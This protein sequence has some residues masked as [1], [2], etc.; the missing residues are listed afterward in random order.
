MRLFV[1][2]TVIVAAV[3]AG[4]QDG[5]RCRG[6]L[7][8][9]HRQ[10]VEGFVA[11]HSLAEA[12]ATLTSIPARPRLRPSEVWR[13]LQQNVLRHFRVVRLETDEVVQVLGDLAL[14][15]IA[16]GL[17]YDALIL[18]CAEKVEARR[19]YTLNVRHFVR[20]RPDLADRISE[21]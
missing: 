1:D 8:T 14:R 9:V 18:R 13:A 19:I 21:P 3:L 10:Q 5:E 20:L 2:T 16:G 4:H 15:D 17:V 12:Y 7:L 11:A 6:C